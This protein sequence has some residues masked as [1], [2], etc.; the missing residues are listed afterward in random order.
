[1]DDLFERMTAWSTLVHAFDRVRENRGAPGVDD[2]TI[3]VFGA[4]LDTALDELRREMID[5][6]YRPAPLR[7]AYLEE[8]SGKLR[9]LAIPTVRDR[10]AQTAAAMV[11]TRLLE[12]EFEDVSF[13]YRPRR[14]VEQAVRRVI[15][16]RNEGYQ[17]V[18]D[19]DI[20]RFFEEID[21][22]RL[23][24]ALAGHAN[25]PRVL[26]VVRL[27]ISGEIQ[28]GALRSRMTRGVPQGS[29]VSPLLAN[30]YLDRFDESLIREGRK[31]VRF[32]DDF[33]ILCKSR[34]AAEGALELSEE[35]LDDLRLALNP[36]KTRITSFEQG[37]SF[38]GVKFLRSL[39]YRPKY[40]EEPEPVEEIPETA[41]D[42]DLPPPAAD[43]DPVLRSLYLMEQGVELGREARR[44]VVRRKGEVVRKI[45][46][47][48]VD[49]IMVFGNI[50]ITTPAMH[51]C[52]KE[53][54]PVFLLSRGGQYRGVVESPQADRVLL[55]R[56]QFARATDP[57]FCLAVAREIVVGKLSNTR[58]LLMR[59]AR[60]TTSPAMKTATTLLGNLARDIPAAKTLD[61]LRGIEGAAAAQY[62]SVWT[63]LVGGAWQFP[64]RRRQPPTDPINSLLS[65]GYTLLFHNTY[66]LMRARGLHPHLGFFHSLR[67]GHPALASDLMEEFR[68]PVVDATVLALFHRKQ[69]KPDDFRFGQGPGGPCLMTEEARR[70]VVQTFEAALSRPIAHPDAGGR[71]DYRRAISL[72]AQRLVAVIKGDQPAYRP[73]VPR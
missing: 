32:A 33:V 55:H 65:Y 20:T 21:H 9:P 3:D 12:P 42:L 7:R 62:F 52:L 70:R 5:G 38:L 11:L 1:M 23:L 10:V 45:P 69:V 49:Q 18:V 39:A 17:W 36:E 19:A 73:F 16:L 58:S 50:G 15:S 29:P 26:A 66:S 61:E 6:T 48:K 64:G 28:D 24:Q 25:D 37:F 54:I 44:F 30:L 34:P 31:L 68:A 51:F 53:D 60:K 13:G 59:A 67:E 63:E 8:D 35:V 2:E 57:S 71:C 22:E 72:Q 43:H 47:M 4:C 27:W 46:A 41:D 56:D 14:S 40:E